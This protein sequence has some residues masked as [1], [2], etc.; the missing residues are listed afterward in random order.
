MDIARL[1]KTRPPKAEFQKKMFEKQQQ[2][3][4][5]IKA[6]MHQQDMRNWAHT[7]G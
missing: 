2:M 5:A 6:E 4:L 3:E 1:L 7:M